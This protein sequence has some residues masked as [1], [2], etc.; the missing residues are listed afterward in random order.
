M[1]DRD[2][3][4]DLDGPPASVQIQLHNILT[5]WVVDWVRI[6]VLG[7]YVVA[8]ESGFVLMF[9]LVMRGHS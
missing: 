7:K 2:I 6:L 8:D 4:I 5:L 9:E 1:V 3:V